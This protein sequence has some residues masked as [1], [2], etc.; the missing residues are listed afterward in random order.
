LRAR[1]WIVT[2]VVLVALTPLAIPAARRNA[3][4]LKLL[5]G[6]PIQAAAGSDT[7]P[8]DLLAMRAAMQ[9]D[10]WD[11][12]ARMLAR[13]TRPDDFA[14]LVVLHEADHRLAIGD[15][16]GARAALDA[17]RRQPGKDYRLAYRLGER[18]ER[19]NAPE[20]AMAVY[21][22]GSAVDPSAPWTEGRFLT[23]KILVR[24]QKW[25][26]LVDLLFPMVRMAPD[27][28]IEQQVRKDQ[29]GGAVWQEILI[30]LG[31]AYERL[32]RGSDA[33]AVY[34]RV[35][36]I[37]RPR[38]DW[39]LNRA[40]VGLS[41]VR[42]MRG[43]FAAAAAPLARGLDL[44]GEFDP[45]Y[46]R[47]FEL[48]TAAEAERLVD[49]AQRSAQ[50]DRLRA[51]VDELAAN[52]AAGAGAWYLGGLVRE[53]ACDAAGA[54]EAYQR[55]AARAPNGAGAFLE[56]RPHTNGSCRLP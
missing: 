47:Q 24:Q 53:A 48:D 35:A 46:R 17:V 40:F 27:D 23:A 26:A 2:A 45:S 4:Y 44:A 30:P 6:Q 55:A 32:G 36:H 39:T 11:T 18:Y 42:R 13:T 3:A 14:P 29:P 43:E 22:A 56:G 8:D 5:R 49:A 12:A 54:A 31:D 20:E 10:D 50:L 37:E 51:A 28:A 16:A 34:Q 41:R 7:L 52:P 21:A 9:H 38:R 25:Q 19:V 15:A 1:I 33:E